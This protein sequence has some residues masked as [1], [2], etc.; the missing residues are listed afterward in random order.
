MPA[1]LIVTRVLGFL[2]FAE[3]EYR[4]LAD[5]CRIAAAEAEKGALEHVDVGVVKILNARARRF[6]EMAVRMDL[7]ARVL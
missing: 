4:T 2:H 6:R 3:P 1:P 7:A 5:A